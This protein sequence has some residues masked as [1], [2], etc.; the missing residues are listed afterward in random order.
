MT[1]VHELTRSMPVLDGGDTHK[2]S[3]AGA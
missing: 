3:M 1:E 2:C